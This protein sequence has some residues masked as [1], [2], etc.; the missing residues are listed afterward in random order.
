MHGLGTPP[1]CAILEPH[2]TCTVQTIDRVHI[3]G[4]YCTTPSSLPE[5]APL[6]ALNRPPAARASAAS[7]LVDDV[8][9]VVGGETFSGVTPVNLVVFNTTSRKW[10]NISIANGSPTPKIRYDHSLV[11]FKVSPQLLKETPQNRLYMFGGVVDRKTISGELWSFD[12]LSRR[13]HLESTSLPLTTNSSAAPLA[14]A[15]HSAHVLNNEMYVFFGYNE[16]FGFNYRVQVYNF[17]KFSV[18]C[19]GGVNHIFARNN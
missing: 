15:G 18:F 19:P 5:W 13:W 3:A 12:M 11:K 7:I 14:V 17:G 8:L 10:S 2:C 4:V 6:W 1:W 9:W 16:K